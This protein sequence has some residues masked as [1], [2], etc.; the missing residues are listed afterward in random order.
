MPLRCLSQFLPEIKERLLRRG[1]GGG[2]ENV[3]RMRAYEY[4]YQNAYQSAY[5]SVYQSAY[6]SRWGGLVFI[7][8]VQPVGW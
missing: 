8:D 6:F 4:A 5:Q 1:G 3:L 2:G 7:V